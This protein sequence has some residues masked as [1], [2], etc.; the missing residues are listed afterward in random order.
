LNADEVDD[1]TDRL[2]DDDRSAVSPTPD[3]DD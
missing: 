3:Q 1:G 2:D